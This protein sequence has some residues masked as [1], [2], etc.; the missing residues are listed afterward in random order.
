M[1]EK[2][3]KK[4]KKAIEETMDWLIENTYPKVKAIK[5]KKK[6]FEKKVQPII[7]KFYKESAHV[8]SRPPSSNANHVI[9]DEL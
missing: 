3:K 2:E 1:N 7:T 8:H 9:R 4:I 5:K 6:A